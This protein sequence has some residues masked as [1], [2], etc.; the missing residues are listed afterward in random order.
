MRSVILKSAIL[1]GLGAAMIATAGCRY[2]D[3]PR[4]RDLSVSPYDNVKMT[5]HPTRDRAVV[6]EVV[7]FT[8][9]TENLLGRDA[10]IEW[11]AP[12]GELRI[13]EDGRVARV[14]YDEPGTY[15]VTA[16]LF[17]DNFEVRRDTRTVTVNPLP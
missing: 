9:N 2:D 17:I 3:R 5:V 6:G 4:D 13:Q 15:S 11:R 1:A 14:I 8:A 10:N 12:G 7:T 16:R